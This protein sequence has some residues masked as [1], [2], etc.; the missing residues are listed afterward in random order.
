MRNISIKRNTGVVSS[1]STRRSTK[2]ALCFC[3]F[4]F[5][6]RSHLTQMWH[7]QS[8][9][10]RRTDVVHVLLLRISEGL[11]FTNSTAQ[12]ARV[13][14]IFFFVISVFI[15]VDIRPTSLFQALGQ[16]A[17]RR[18]SAWAKK[19]RGGL[20]LACFFT[21]DYPRAWNRLYQEHEQQGLFEEWHQE[22]QE[23][24]KRK[25]NDVKFNVL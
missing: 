10:S 14:R 24:Q 16:C 17:A 7:K 2:R 8:I 3:W 4:L 18:K 12:A 6:P 15:L 19:K 5:H 13:L 25:V 20:L 21:P 1:I 11:L 22:Y 9:S 23:T